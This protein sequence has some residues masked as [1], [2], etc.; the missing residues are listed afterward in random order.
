MSI[1]ESIER[2]VVTWLLGTLAT[3]FV[4]GFGAYGTILNVSNQ[5]TIPQNVKLDLEQRALRADEVEGEIA[6]LRAREGKPPAGH[7]LQITSDLVDRQS[8]D[9][10]EEVELD[11]RFYIVSKWLGVTPNAYYEETWEIRDSE[12]LLEQKWQPFVPTDQTYAV[13]AS[14]LLPSTENEPGRYRVRV[15]G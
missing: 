13:W 2:N 15:L 1:R 4:A 11:R 14:F 7:R 9:T 12:G 8:V 3:G 6:Q 10:L 5:V